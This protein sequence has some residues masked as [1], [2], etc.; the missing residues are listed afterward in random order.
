MNTQINKTKLSIRKKISIIILTIFQIFLFIFLIIEEVHFLVSL[1]INAFLYLFFLGL[2]IK[3]KDIH[4]NLLKTHN[5]NESTM[6]KSKQKFKIET[7][8]GV[9]SDALKD[10]YNRPLVRRCENCGFILPRFG[11]KCPICGHPLQ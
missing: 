1:L 9:K 3:S 2:I 11:K 7:T 10:T 5:K 6:E 4:L 8:K